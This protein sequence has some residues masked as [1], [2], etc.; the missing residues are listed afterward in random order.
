MKVLAHLIQIRDGVLHAT[1][2]R[3]HKVTNDGSKLVTAAPLN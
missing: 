1:K 2:V 3:H